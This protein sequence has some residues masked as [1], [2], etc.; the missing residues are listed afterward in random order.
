MT[1]KKKNGKKN[2]WLKY[3]P[4]GIAVIV[5][6]TFVGNFVV[7]PTINAYSNLKAK[8]ATLEVVHGELRA[9]DGVMKAEIKHNADT[10]KSMDEKL[11]IIIAALG[12]EG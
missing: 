9:A 5:A 12:A 1:E 10:I 8:D 7:I 2:G 6:L 11:D 3:V 4:V